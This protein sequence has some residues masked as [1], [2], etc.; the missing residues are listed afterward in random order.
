MN[1]LIHRIVLLVLCVVATGVVEARAQRC[2]DSKKATTPTSDFVINDNGTAVHKKTGL[3]WKRCIE[4]TKGKSCS[5]KPKKLFWDDMTKEY[6]SNSFAGMRG[7]RVP[8]VDE[9]K[10]IVEK[11][12]KGP[13]LNLEVFPDA[14]TLPN[15]TSSEIEGGGGK[16][17]QMYITSGVAIKAN[18]AVGSALRLVR[19][20]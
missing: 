13:A 5:G 17:W 20:P 11:K 16:A 6:K 3:M 2:K 9:L 12:C 19:T 7:W 1:N 4:G 18:K 15:W 14:S 8:S 10:S